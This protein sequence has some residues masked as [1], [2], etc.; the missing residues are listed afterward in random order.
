LKCEICGKNI[1]L[2]FQCS[3]C[4]GNF[5]V[6]HRLPENHSCLNSPPRT[7]LG[8]WKGK[9]IP[10]IKEPLHLPTMLESEPMPTRSKANV[11]LLLI[12]I[13]IIAVSSIVTGSFYVQNIGLQNEKDHIEGAISNLED[14]IVSLESQ[15]SSLQSE[16]STNY[17]LGYE[18][19]YI[20]GVE[21]G[22]GKG[23]NIRDPTYQES[24][25][26]VS[27]DQTD[28]NQYDEESY[29]CRHFTADFKNNA[30]EAGYRCGYVAIEYPVLAHAIVCFD[31]TDH[32]LIF[33]EPQWDDV[34]T[35]TLGQSYSNLNSYGI[36]DYDDTI[37]D[38]TIIW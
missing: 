9:K 25:H 33:I 17:D 18:S 26:F 30:F 15:L 29:T 27:L 13:G 21:D 34:V 38:F 16:V 35:L 7:P 22:V 28:K 8:P 37:V 11:T 6:E 4:S 1:E 10:E 24:L 5:C 32:G 19:G 23:Y 12:M 3:F 36:P 20:Q 14:E 2:P 31:T